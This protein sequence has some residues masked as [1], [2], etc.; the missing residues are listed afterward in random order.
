MSRGDPLTE[1]SVAALVQRYRRQ[2]PAGAASEAS[3][4]GARL[5]HED[6]RISPFRR[7]FAATEV[8]THALPGTHLCTLG[9]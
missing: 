8:R 6:P 2:R 9:P 1:E 3:S 4:P 7:Q 5:A